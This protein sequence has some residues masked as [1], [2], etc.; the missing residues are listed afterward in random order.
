LLNPLSE[1]WRFRMRQCFTYAELDRNRKTAY[2]PKTAQLRVDRSRWNPDRPLSG[3]NPSWAAFDR[4]LCRSG[5][6]ITTIILESHP[7]SRALLRISWTCPLHWQC[8]TNAVF[9]IPNIKT[10]PA[11]RVLQSPWLF[12]GCSWATGHYALHAQAANKAP[13]PKGLPTNHR[14][15]HPQA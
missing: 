6:C 5:A 4:C 11:P 9:C 2:P 10:S 14:P 8:D 7:P 13:T 15:H 1:R 12:L 3:R